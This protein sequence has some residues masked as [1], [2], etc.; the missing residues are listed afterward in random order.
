VGPL[1]SGGLRRPAIL[2][3]PCRDWKSCPTDSERPQ[4][5]RKEKSS[6]LEIRNKFKIQSTNQTPP[7]VQASQTAK[8]QRTGSILRFSKL[9]HWSGAHPVSVWRAAISCRGGRVV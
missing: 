5:S 2:R 7:G 6:K 9:P 3:R 4:I 8:L 1:V